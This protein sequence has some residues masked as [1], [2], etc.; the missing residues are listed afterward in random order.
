MNDPHTL[1]DAFAELERRGDAAAARMSDQLPRRARP[2][3]RLVPVAVAAAVVAGLATGVALFAPGDDAGTTAG[4]TPSDRST[5]I[6]TTL[7][8]PASIVPNTPEDL[9]A[10]FRTVLGDLATFTVTD[11]GT[12]M[13]I[14][15]PGGPA[16]SQQTPPPDGTPT[17]D[18]QQAPPSDATP[19]GAAIIGA[20]TSAG[21]TG[22]Y[23]IQIY[24]ATETETEAWCD[25]Q[26][27]AMCT[28]RQL[29]DGSSLA[30]G[31]TTTLEGPDGGITY[32][33]VVVRPNGVTTLMHLSNLSDPKGAGNLL[34]AQPPLTTDQMVTIVTS[35]RW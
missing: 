28:V 13:A 3:S 27:P 12:P 11:T 18:R 23:D 30:V 29:P 20:L 17:G 8:S 14:T 21:T 26:D 10:R 25:N 6:T 4:A 35:N 15:V 1:T 24:Q 5:T 2:T 22:G 9:A 16:D 33:V 7:T 32:Q 34:A 31:T 19:T